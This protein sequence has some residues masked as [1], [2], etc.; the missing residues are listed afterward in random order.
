LSLAGSGLLWQLGKGVSDY[1]VTVKGRMFLDL[2]GLILKEWDSPSQEFSPELAYILERLDLD[3]HMSRFIKSFYGSDPEW[4]PGS[5]MAL[6]IGTILS[7]RSTWK[8]DLTHNGYI[9]HEQDSYP[10]D[11]I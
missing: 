5:T 11:R 4:S 6:L 10:G 7:A 9:V 1:G 8:I 2:L 3:V